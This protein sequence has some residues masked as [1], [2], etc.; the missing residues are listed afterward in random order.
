MMDL[1][2]NLQKT[3][4]ALWTCATKNVAWAVAELWACARKK[5][6]LQK[7][8][9][10][11]LAALWTCA[12]KNLCCK[13]CAMSRYCIVK[14]CWIKLVL[15][16]NVPWA[17]TALWTCVEQNLCSKKMCHE[18]LLHCKHVLQKKLCCKKKWHE[19]LPQGIELKTSSNCLRQNVK[20]LH[21][22]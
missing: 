21:K 8:V 22:C 7:N 20:V 5:L 3:C 14:M 19:K 13:K 12:E 2:W 4:A 1:Y 6:V 10:W 18:P 11:A 15:Q 9:W 17:T 16:K